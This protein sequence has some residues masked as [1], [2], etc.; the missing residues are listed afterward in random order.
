VQN[1]RVN[2]SLSSD[3]TNSQ[4]RHAHKGETNQG[5]MK[6]GLS[7]KSFPF[8]PVVVVII[9]LCFLPSTYNNC[10]IETCILSLHVLARSSHHQA[11]YR[12]QH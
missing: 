1:V 9:K 6:Q 3:K 7:C 10:I 4:W 2:T 11:L 8:H 5:V 12:T